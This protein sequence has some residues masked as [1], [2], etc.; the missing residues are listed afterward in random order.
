MTERLRHGNEPQRSA[1]AGFGHVAFSF[2]ATWIG[3]KQFRRETAA[4]IRI[5]LILY[6]WPRCEQME[7]GM[8][9]KSGNFSSDGSFADALAVMA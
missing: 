3:Q 9:L 4:C 5:H 8:A 6:A 1:S 7:V 2:A